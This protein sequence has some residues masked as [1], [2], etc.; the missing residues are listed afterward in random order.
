MSA[1]LNCRSQ[2]QPNVVWTASA[3]HQR[4]PNERV[5]DALT[6]EEHHLAAAKA[7]RQRRGRRAAE[8]GEEA[9]DGAVV[10]WEHDGDV[11]VLELRAAHRAGDLALAA[12][13]RAVAVRERE[14]RPREERRE[15]DDVV[16]RERRRGRGFDS[17]GG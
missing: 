17:C 5:S 13:H 7:A 15:A 2:E 1:R 12:V 10:P 11:R 6:R 3:H 4:R 14:A 8:V 16:A 9:F